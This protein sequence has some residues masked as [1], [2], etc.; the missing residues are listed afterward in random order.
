M[1]DLL[2]FLAHLGDWYFGASTYF[3]DRLIVGKDF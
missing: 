3:Y 2:L 1:S